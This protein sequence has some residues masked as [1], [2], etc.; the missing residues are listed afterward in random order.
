MD[1]KVEYGAVLLVG[2]LMA[3]G[4]FQLGKASAPPQMRMNGQPPIAQVNETSSRMSEPCPDPVPAAPVHLADV[5][6]RREAEPI[7][8]C[9]AICDG[10]VGM[11]AANPNTGAMSNCSCM[12]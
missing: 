3:I 12:R 2:G 6:F 9:V 7:L 11:Y 8:R 10:R 1:I 4:I 5:Q